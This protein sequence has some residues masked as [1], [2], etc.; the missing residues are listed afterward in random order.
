MGIVQVRDDKGRWSVHNDEW[1]AFEIPSIRTVLRC[2]GC[3][4][5]K[6]LFKDEDECSEC[7]ESGQVWVP[8]GC[9]LA[10]QEKVL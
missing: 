5:A 3:G 6:P 7:G 4:K 10:A 1:D 8:L 2:L 9:L